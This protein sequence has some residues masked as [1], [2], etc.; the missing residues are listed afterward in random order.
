MRAPPVP[1]HKVSGVSN[2][3][4]EKIK[5]LAKKSLYFVCTHFLG[6]TDWDKV[7]D[8]M[9]VFLLRPAR[10][11]ALLLPRN[12]LK[13]TFATISFP[14]LQI[15]KNPNIRILIANGVWDMARKFLDE[16][17]AQLENSQLKYLFGDFVSARWNA[18]EI[19]VRQRTKSLKEPTIMTTG[20]EAETTGGHYDLIILD[21]LMG[22]QNT[23]TPEQREKVKKFRRSMLNLLEP[24]GLLIEV[25]TRWHLD[26]TFSEILEKE[27]KY[28]DI[29][30]RRVVE[31]GK[32]IFPKK[33]A[34]KFNEKMKCWE[35]VDDPT[36]MD[37][38]DHLKASMPL[39][40][41][42]AQ[43]LNAPFSSQNQLF[44]N[45]YFKYWN[46]RPR[47]LFTAMTIDLASSAEMYADETAMV[48]TGMDSNWNIYVL[49]YIKGRWG[50]ASEVVDRIFEMREKWK[51]NTVGM[52]I[53]GYQ[54]IYKLACEAEMRKR[55]TY[56]PIEEIKTG[57]TRTK[58]E[59]IKTLEPFYRD[60]KV[61]HAAWM[62][63]KDLEA[64][65]QMISQDG[66][67]GKRDDLADALSM[68]LPLLNPGAAPTAESDKEWTWD[69]CIRQ[70]MA[71]SRPYE[72]FFNY[73][74]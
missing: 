12:H 74:R 24:K 1:K 6:Y 15:I 48:I 3:Q 43:Y 33:F 19:I 11:K 60:R 21:D 57:P 29:M 13:S 70:A 69:W 53:M 39:D 37:Y 59:R 25:M 20:V 35:A 8:D 34:Q 67:K 7:H 49:D 9:E 52:E 30:L 71:N 68:A 5:E 26:D 38:I 51:P 56:F 55:R 65:L 31:N 64:Q 44:R 58:F 46:E 17:K 32:L 27:R 72:G 63:R 10:K 36:C 18:D 73:G 47:D 23:Q 54:R 50:T 61:H 66:L 42:S 14:I 22:L 4:L 62:Q 2:E 40:E 45:E 28:Y 16:I 41:F